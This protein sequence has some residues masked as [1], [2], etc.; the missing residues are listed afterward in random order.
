MGVETYERNGVRLVVY[1]GEETGSDEYCAYR[2]AV[3]VGERT[4]FVITGC[5]DLT[6]DVEEPA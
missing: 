3:I 2:I 1:E 5:H 6:P 4:L